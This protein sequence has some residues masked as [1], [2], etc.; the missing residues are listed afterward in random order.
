MTVERKVRESQTSLIASL[1]NE[2]KQARDE[3]KKLSAALETRDTDYTQLKREYHTL[4]YGGL[5][6]KHRYM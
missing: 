1:E 4:A 5:H 6:V 2:L 3:K